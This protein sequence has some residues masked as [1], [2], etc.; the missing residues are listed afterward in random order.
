MKRTFILQ[1]KVLSPLFGL[2]LAITCVAQQPGK[3]TI[4]GKITDA[5]NQ[6]L[7]G[8]SV[9]VKGKP[10]GAISD[11]SGVFRI[12]N[13]EAGDVTLQISAVGYAT[14][15]QTV[16][17]RSGA[18]TVLDVELRPSEMQLQTVEIVGR[19]ETTYTNGSTFIG[20]KS[21]T[22]LKD[23]PQSVSY[24]TKEL[25]QD[26]AAFRVNEVLKNMS[27]VNQASFYNDLTI[28]GNR[29]SGQEN[30]SMLV[31][32]M[33]SFSN[34][35]KQLL[36]PHIEQVEILKG[37]ASALYGNAA[38]GGTL[39]RV[40]KKPLDERRMSVGTTV[41][42]F[43]TFRTTADF[44]GPMNEGKTLLYRLNL[45]LEDSESFRDLQ[46][47]KS[48]ILAPSFSFL[49]NDKT[50]FNVDL[51]YQTANTRLDR[52]HAVFGDGDL[53]SVPINRSLSVMNDYL[54]EKSYNVTLSLNHRFAKNLSFSSAYM[55]TSFD[56]D[57]LEHRTANT[58]AKDSAG[59]I[60]PTKVEMQVFI[61]KR[62]WNNANLVNYFNYDFN[63]G[64]LQNRLVVGY[65][66]A[67]Q[68]LRPGGSQLV[69]SGYRNAAN[70][71]AI[72]TF[73]PANRSRYLLDAARS[74]VPNVAHID[75]TNPDP[76]ALRDVSKYF[77]TTRL[78]PQ[79]FFS[80]QGFYMQDQIRLGRFQALLGFR[81]DNFTEF[82]DYKTNTEKKITQSAFIPRLGLV[83]SLNPNINAYATYVGGYQPQT[84]A[85]LANPAAGGP[86][87]PLIS[88]LFEGGLKT[89]WLDRRLTATM[90]IYQL[91]QKGT[92]YNAGDTQNPDKL[93]QIGEEL[94]R[95][96]ELDIIG[97]LAANWNVIVNYAYCDAAITASKVEAEIGRQKPNAP[98]H[99]W[100]LWTKYMLDR[101]SLSGLGVGLG[102]NYQSGFLG[103]IVPAGQAPKQFPSYQ[104]FNAAVYYR[105]S[106]IQ[107][108]MNLNNLTNKTHWV[109][110]Y[111]YLR[112]FPG[113]PRSW[114]ASVSYTF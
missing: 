104:L 51:V 33:R 57:L 70:T 4:S 24:V 11:A 38:P 47:D 17:V 59:A 109:G 79:S 44:T 97:Q 100:N 78:F 68:V 48:I 103:S 19:K 77:F 84:A 92:L 111:D 31:N 23:L 3:G 66:Y 87:D 2:L 29:V 30:Y 15:S 58:Y 113:S 86:F 75:L 76:Y 62:T 39:N 110:G 14:Q 65:D 53:F 99:L 20:S 35:W 45:G 85:N 61:R 21:A 13:V 56:E 67:Q 96:V 1:S 5:K 50:R 55:F 114:L 95:G 93:V 69:A 10:I 106:K 46:F 98:K 27:G 83:Y 71:G 72:A 108:Q 40:T 16:L 74:P 105:V 90:A 63:I 9:G 60:I 8:V 7:P 6:T 112:A 91:A 22:P 28:R 88:T 12:E 89:E 107:L 73:V 64:K 34:F 80:T 102:T 36:I 49:P 26:Q 42:N 37:P 18:T 94:T 43:G 81:Q 82:V 101:G 32:G 41:G 25:I 52:G 54:K